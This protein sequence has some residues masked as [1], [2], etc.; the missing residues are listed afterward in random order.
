M[1]A[2]VR[3]FADATARAAASPPP[4]ANTLSLL[5]SN[6]GQVDYWTG[7]A[8]APAGVF[9][10]SMA[11]NELYQQSGPYTGGQ[12][13]TYM[14]RKV[15]TITD[16]IGLFDVIPAVDLAG[17]AGVIS[18]TVQ[19]IAADVGSLVTPYSVIVVPSGGAIKGATYRLD[20]GQPLALSPVSVTVTALVY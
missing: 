1:N 5:A 15:T 8:W 6:P 7:T 4:T 20:D 14:V 17:K 9:L 11:G 18:A 16:D 10:L 2:T 12:R 3:K 13:V 19:V